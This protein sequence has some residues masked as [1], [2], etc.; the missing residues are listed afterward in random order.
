LG[1]SPRTF[2]NSIGATVT[3]DNNG[4]YPMLR[5]NAQGG[6]HTV[7]VDR[8]VPALAFELFN[9]S[10]RFGRDIKATT[11]D[12]KPSIKV[13]TGSMAGIVYKPTTNEQ[14]ERNLNFALANL[15]AYEEWERTGR[16]VAEA[17]E[18]ALKAA[19]KRVAEEKAK[20][21]AEEAK[22]Q[23]EHARKRA[24][25]LTFY[26]LTNGTRFY[27][28]S[29]VGLIG[30]ARIQQWIDLSESAKALKKY[31][32]IGGSSLRPTLYPSSNPFS[33]FSL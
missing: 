11:Q 26:N 6:I 27:S 19:E 5:T 25:A 14:A 8:D 31:S 4:I 12:G 16:K 23:A 9:K 22:R 2:T 13:G 33:R 28:W 18:A 15:A 24:D 20:R 1:L 30:E 21:E 10:A 17:R 32:P 3:V 7:V 29:S